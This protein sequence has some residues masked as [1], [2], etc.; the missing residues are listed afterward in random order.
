[1]R[2]G[3]ALIT[4]V[5]HVSIRVWKHTVFRLEH[6]GYEMFSGDNNSL[7]YLMGKS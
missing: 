2:R 3:E 5:S 4:S 1:M 6:V 7:P